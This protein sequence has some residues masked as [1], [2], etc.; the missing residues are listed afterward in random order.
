MKKLILAAM[1]VVS[2]SGSLFAANECIS[3]H[4]ISDW[5]YAGRDTL[6]F[7]VFS[8]R[9]YNMT[10]YSCFELMWAERI[11]FRTWAPNSSR[12]CPG[13]DLLLLDYSGRRIINSCR[14]RNIER[15]K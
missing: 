11:A 12:V 7:R 1:L 8:K 3:I 14:I 9:V 6:E 13:D 5:R 15:I 2:F 10:T 4:S